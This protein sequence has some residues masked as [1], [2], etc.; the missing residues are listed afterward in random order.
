MHHTTPSCAHTNALRHGAAFGCRALPAL[1]LMLLAACGSGDP[2]APP[3]AGTHTVSVTVSG[4]RHSYDGATL[5]NNGGDDLRVYAD[6]TY[7]FATPVAD[8]ST[9]AVTVS[10]QPTGPAQTC[11]VANGSGTMSGSNVSNVAVS[12][13][14]ATAY[15]VG[16]SVSGLAGN[17]LQLEYDADNVSLP[18]VRTVAANGSFSFDATT[19][20]AINGTAYRL[21]I[22]SQPTGPAQTC[23]LTAGTGTVAAADVSSVRVVCDNH[24]VRIS[25]TGMRDTNV[26]RLV[27][28]GVDIIG[29]GA[30]TGPYQFTAPV[31][32][33]S[34]YNVTILQQPTTPA[35]TCVVSNGSGIMGD[36][37]VTVGIDC[38]YPPAYS[39]GGTVAGLASATDRVSVFYG[40]SNVN[41][42]IDR[43]FANGPFVFTAAEVSPV[44]GTVY[45]VTI[46][47]QP[48]GQRCDVVGGNGT[49]GAGDVT[50]IRITCV[51]ASVAS[52]CTPPVGAGTTH[53][54]VSTPETW[55]EAGSPHILPFDISIY[56]AVTIEP[57]A[58]VRIASKATVTV[59][60]GG[61]LVAQGQLARPVTF[62]PRVADQAWSSIRNLGGTLSL[63]HA[64][65]T[66]GGDPLNTNVA[67]AGALHMQS[68]L[69]TGGILHVDDV[70]IVGSLSQ[71]VYVN[72]PIGFDASSRNLR[73]HGSASFPVHVYAR[74]IGSIP[75]GT[76]TG[77]G[78]DAI[79]IAGTGG[80]VL[81]AQ[82]MR[83]RG[84]PYHVGSTGQDGGR[85]DVDSQVA[86]QV[87]V[88]TIEPGVTIQ[89][90]PGGIFNV[91]LGS[92]TAAAK[93][94]LVA[95][96]GTDAADRIVFTSDRGASSQ[97]GD[98]LGIAFGGAVDPR[99]VMQNVRV[100]FAGGTSTTGSNSCPYPGNN[101][102]NDAAIRIFGP[103]LA[104]FI[105]G[106]EIRA[107]L[108][109]GID[110][111]WRSDLQP[112]FLSGNTFTAVATCKQTVPRT[113]AGLCPLVLPCP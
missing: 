15:A 23:I 106:T 100:E 56:S 66:G 72:G 17:G 88:L 90:P 58:V 57:C 11:S 92:G 46:A 102:I 22:L 91:G 5:R 14:Y 19:T 55:T 95:I 8:G 13:P 44:A 101:G 47:S 12:C 84:V 73:V 35:Q 94:A 10:A 32:T 33:G 36:S 77:N 98:W 104:Q 63:S 6:G 68:P 78:R 21:R 4:L 108:H 18:A 52:T 112:D 99:S 28:N 3:P 38:P 85:M 25:L 75:T 86:G 70:E 7:A 53:G 110:R 65:L 96:G 97:A 62:E 80:P 16:G 60:P 103:P 24:L 45:A 61:S 41:F 87:A 76:Y 79:A 81:D 9:Y 74:V 82:T 37:D 48:V 105:T 59:N 113:A 109:H 50:S 42:F 49:V 71:G 69:A 93:G 67:L 111:G 26:I 107:S 20:S 1:L 29:V 39:V 43:L 34:P 83:A 30:H 2:T 31:A 64:V 54:S 40:A 27:N 89:F 51:P